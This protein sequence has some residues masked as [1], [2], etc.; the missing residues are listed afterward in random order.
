MQPLLPIVIENPV[1]LKIVVTLQQQSVLVL[2]ACRC[3]MAIPWE[4]TGLAQ[5]IWCHGAAPLPLYG[6]ILFQGRDNE[7]G[8]DSNMSP[9]IVWIGTPS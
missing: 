4:A 6:T 9:A 1:V 5:V 8:T 2:R 7:R 3:C